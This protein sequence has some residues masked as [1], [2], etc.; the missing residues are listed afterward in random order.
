M[1]EIKET[2]HRPTSARSINFLHDSTLR[3]SVN[4]LAGVLDVHPTTIDN[5]VRRKIITRAPVGKRQLRNRLFSA[6]DIY[7]AAL[8]NELV[9][10]G[11]PPSSATDAVSVL[12][13]KWND[14]PAERNLYAIVSPKHGKWAVTLCSQSKTGGLLYKFGKAGAIK[15]DEEVELPKQTFAVIPISDVLNRVQCKLSELLS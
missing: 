5:W 12:W 10:L 7:S 6:K 15:T 1:T 14:P 11:L 13:T 8:T 9:K 2:Q 3:I 4:E